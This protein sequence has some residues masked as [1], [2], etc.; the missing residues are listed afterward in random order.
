M[1]S[2]WLL[3]DSSFWYK[4]F[5]P[6]VVSNTKFTTSLL[7]LYN[8]RILSLKKIDHKVRYPY[9]VLNISILFFYYWITWIIYLKI[10]NIF[11]LIVFTRISIIL[12]NKI[13]DKV[14]WLQNIGIALMK[15]LLTQQK[16]H[17]ETIGLAVPCAM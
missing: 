16:C 17:Y 8:V 1:K 2:H 4:K 10:N 6:E 14:S 15:A 9:Y 5:S 13:L 12:L 3:I 7:T 11:L